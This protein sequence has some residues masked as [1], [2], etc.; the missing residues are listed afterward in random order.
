MHDSTAPLV[1]FDGIDKA[2]DGAAKVVDDLHLQI[3]RGEFLTLLGPS[4]SGKTT[5]LMMLAGF[6]TPTRGTILFDGAPLNKVP[7]Y[8]RDFGIV[9]Q[10]Y[11]LFPHMSVADNL[12]FPLRMRGVGKSD[13][14]AAVRKTLDMVK[15]TRLADRMPRQLSGGEQQRVALARALV[16][17]PRMVLMD[18]PLGALDKQLREHM[19][20]EI[21]RLHA[22]LGIAML[23]VTHDQG[24]A[25]TM[26]DRIAVFDAGRLQQIGT[27]RDVYSNPASAFVASFMGEN[28]RLAAKVIAL[29]DGIAQVAT[30]AGG[31]IVRAGSHGAGV[32][33]A[34]TLMLRPE[35][36]AIPPRPHHENQFS[37]TVTEV[38]YHGDHVRLCIAIA[39]FG[40]LVA[41]HPIGEDEAEFLSGQSVALSWAAR[42]MQ[43][44]SG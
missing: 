10:N 27:P 39:G 42:T 17:A 30:T 6:E 34:V 1:V 26:S 31:E 35:T 37:G 33:Q 3:R 23:Y 18:E 15:L 24:E 28:N 36:I 22:E 12:G 2:Y 20:L 40:T 38:V 5:I 13:I 41:R 43:A 29:A 4:G 16:F 32:G 14:A 11:A 19:Q 25:L 8:R 7:T 21:K 44:F 9:F